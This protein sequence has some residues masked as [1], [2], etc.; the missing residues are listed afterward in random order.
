MTTHANGHEAIGSI[1]N[2]PLDDEESGPGKPSGPPDRSG[3]TPASLI[4]SRRTAPPLPTASSEEIA[5]LRE[6]RRQEVLNAY[7]PK[8]QEESLA[9]MRR[10]DELLEQSRRLTMDIN[11]LEEFFDTLFKNDLLS[12]SSKAQ[13]TQTSSAKLTANGP[14]QNIPAAIAKVPKRKGYR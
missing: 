8:S 4:F 6:R 3:G 7:A 10:F 11:E 12:W 9:C 13:D 14:S 2:S 5:E 1:S